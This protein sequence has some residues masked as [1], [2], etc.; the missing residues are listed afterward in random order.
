MVMEQQQP[1]AAVVAPNRNAA[2][3]EPAVLPPPPSSVVHHPYQHLL[4][5][6]LHGTIV[7]LSVL[8]YVLLRK[9]QALLDDLQALEEA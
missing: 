4:D 9:I 6:L 8:C 1:P 7:V 2:P 5:P 3:E